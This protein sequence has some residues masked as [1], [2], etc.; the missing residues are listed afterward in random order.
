MSPGKVKQNF[1]LQGHSWSQRR[2]TGGVRGGCEQNAQGL[3]RLDSRRKGVPGAG[4]DLTMFSVSTGEGVAIQTE[5]R[6]RKER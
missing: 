1:H 3:Q 6:V 2:L 4:D 5:Q